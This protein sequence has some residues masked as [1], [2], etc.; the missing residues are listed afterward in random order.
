[1]TAAEA[2]GTR[3]T[4]LPVDQPYVAYLVDAIGATGEPPNH[5]QSAYFGYLAR[6]IAARGHAAGICGEGADSLFGLGLANQ[7]H[8]ARVIQA[9]VPGR[10]LRR[11]GGALSALLGCP[12]LAATFHL[13]A[14]L[15]RFDDPAHPVNQV[16]MFTHL[17]AVEAMFGTGA[18]REAMAARRSLVDRFAVGDDPMEFLHAAGFLGEAMDSASL[19]TSLFNVAG[20]DLLCPFLDSRMLRFALSLS[21]GVRFRF[22]RPKSLLRQALADVVG[23]SFAHRPKLGFGQPIFE[24]LAP[25][26]SLRRLAEEAGRHPF[27]DPQVHRQALDRPNWFLYSLV[28]FDVWHR[29]FIERSLPRNNAAEAIGASLAANGLLD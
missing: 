5:V 15:N 29:L 10:G 13:A 25:G 3:H 14:C 1:M 21:P 20:I 6:E 7:V 8:N 27:V 24:W 26:G 12:R 9:V 28:C 19:W 2:L 18:V 4:L 16:A 17:P 23:P 22:R 11:L